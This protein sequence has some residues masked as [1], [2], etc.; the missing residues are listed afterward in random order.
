VPPPPR[1]DTIDDT[2]MK[3]LEVSL[4][5]PRASKPATKAP[6]SLDDEMTKL[7]GELA[8]QKR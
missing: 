6:P 4:D 1:Q 2:L 7:L 8:S 5:D 3:E